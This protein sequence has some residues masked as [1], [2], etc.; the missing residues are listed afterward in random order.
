MVKVLYRATQAPMALAL[1][2]ASSCGASANKSTESLLAS[3][4]REMQQEV[5]SLQ[6]VEG[7]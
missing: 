2:S 6:Q 4:Q 3:L 5:S 1:P 7:I